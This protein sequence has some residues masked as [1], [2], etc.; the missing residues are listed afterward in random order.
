MI[1]RIVLATA[2]LATLPCWSAVAET[3]AERRACMTDAQTHCADEIP[4]RERV[5]NCLVQKVSLLSPPCKKIINDS[6]AA[7]RPKGK[8]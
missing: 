1:H 6:L 2:I 7:F 8:R 3:E 5:Y 4:D